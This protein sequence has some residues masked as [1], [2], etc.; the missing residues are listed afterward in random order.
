MLMKFEKVNKKN[1]KPEVYEEFRK[2]SNAKKNENYKNYTYT[3]LDLFRLPRLA[4]ITT[5]LIIYW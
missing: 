2:N 4:R 3:I 5:I 1:L